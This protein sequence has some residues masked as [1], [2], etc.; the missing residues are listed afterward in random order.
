MKTLLGQPT[1]EQIFL[2]NCFVG[3]FRKYIFIY[4]T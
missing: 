2:Q 4:N 1:Q 3:C